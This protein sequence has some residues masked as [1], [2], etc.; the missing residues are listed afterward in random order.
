MRAI[1][2]GITLAI[3]GGITL[4]IVGGITNATVIIH[5][6][7]GFSVTSKP[8]LQPSGVLLT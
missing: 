6:T 1:V 7:E 4:A 8:L 2:L 3:V 5:L